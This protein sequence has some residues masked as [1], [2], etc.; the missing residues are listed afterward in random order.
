VIT[1]I[2]IVAGEIWHALDQ[3]G[4]YR[5]ERLCVA[6]DRPRELVLMSLGWLCREGHVQLEGG[7]EDYRITLRKRG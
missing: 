2:G 4:E 6:L 3:A 5:L 1:E 7:G